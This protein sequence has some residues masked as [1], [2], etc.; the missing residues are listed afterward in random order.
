MRN[1]LLLL[2]TILAG[3]SLLACADGPC[4]DV[5]GPVLYAWDDTVDHRLEGTNPLAYD[6]IGAAVDAAAPGTTICISAG[7]W[8]EELHIQKEGI[9]LRGAGPTR[10]ILEPH[11]PYSDPRESDATI[12]EISA[13][14]VSLH[15]LQLR[16]GRIGLRL[17]EGTNTTLREIEMR[18]NTMGLSSKNIAG[19]DARG[20]A[21]V[22]NTAV[23]GL[24]EH[25]DSSPFPL[26]LMDIRVEGNGQHGVSAVG[27]IRSEHPL[28]L[29]RAH[30]QDNTGV[31]AGDLMTQGLDALDLSVGQP[32]AKDNAPRIRVEGKTIVHEALIH[33]L[34]GG[35]DIDCQGENLGMVNVAL[36]DADPG[37]D[38]PALMQLTDCRGELQHLTLAKLV[39]EAR[40]IGLRVLGD[41]QV[42]L[43]NS[44]LVHFQQ[45]VSATEESLKEDRN[46]Q[47]NLTEAAL[48]SPIGAQPNLRPQRDSPL[49]DAASEQ[50]IQ[51]DLEGWSRPLG[52]APDIGAYERR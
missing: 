5:D 13:P 6:S 24:F 22:R 35:L 33:L 4:A 3:S 44:A 17:N 12:L 50:G 9:A 40:G 15:G 2:T 10:T 32:F 48:L 23:G 39:G 11:H 1:P 16:G 47:G 36:S 46:F 43:K 8:Q 21:L 34:G 38:S 19:L 7:I 51:R 42:I 37:N 27:G 20:V 31:E 29:T 26:E 52:G 25:K 41:S 18:T 28:V 14:H 49:I 45:P 30:F